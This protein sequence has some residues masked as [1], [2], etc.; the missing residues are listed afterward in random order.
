[1]RARLRGAERRLPARDD[2]QPVHL[3]L[4]ELAGIER[5]DRHEQIRAAPQA[6]ESRGRDADDRERPALDR[7]GPANDAWIGVVAALPVL[8]TDD[9]LRRRASTRVERTIEISADDW[10]DTE[11]AEVRR[12]HDLGAGPLD[13]AR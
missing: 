10:T 5:R 6:F 7:D 9:H 2:V 4:I 1:R 12:A 8:R 13:V 3:R 11:R